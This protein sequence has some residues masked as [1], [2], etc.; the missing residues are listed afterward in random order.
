MKTFNEKL[1]N[2]N[3]CHASD[4][5]RDQQ[6]SNTGTARAFDLANAL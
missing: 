5:S 1:A 3:S 2:W 6:Y 4:R